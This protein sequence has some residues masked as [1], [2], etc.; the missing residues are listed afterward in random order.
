MTADKLKQALG[1]L[2]EQLFDAVALL[3]CLDRALE[4]EG[5][6]DQSRAASAISGQLSSIAIALGEVIG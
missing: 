5:H 3:R 1:D 4:A 6:D 2:Q